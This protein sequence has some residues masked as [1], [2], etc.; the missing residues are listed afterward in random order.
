MKA[1][2]IFLALLLSSCH[3]NI[4]E[5]LEALRAE[6]ASQQAEIK[7]LNTFVD[8][9]AE[10]LRACQTAV[11]QV[12]DYLVN[13]NAIGMLRENG[14]Q[15]ERLGECSDAMRRFNAIATSTTPE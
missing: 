15:L 4:N 3:S 9:Q 1:A 14:S 7:R 10:V 6:Q 11:D 5:E 8:A 13:T 12:T 2:M